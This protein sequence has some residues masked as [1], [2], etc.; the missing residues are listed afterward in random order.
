MSNLAKTMDTIADL[1]KSH[2]VKQKRWQTLYTG[3]A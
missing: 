2:G 3:C 1:H